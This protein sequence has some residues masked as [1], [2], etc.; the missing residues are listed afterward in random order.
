M[1]IEGNPPSSKG[2]G[3]R[4]TLRKGA[5]VHKAATALAKEPGESKIKSLQQ[6]QQSLQADIVQLRADVATRDERLRMA[7]EVGSA[8]EAIAEEE[9]RVAEE[10]L[11]MLEER[12]A[13][14]RAVSEAQ[15]GSAATFTAVESDAA[16]LLARAHAERF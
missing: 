7:R 16:A 11:A 10:E 1:A 15:L 6:K 14:D 2:A 8:H 3:L 5:T 13:H 9:L 12:A 4:A